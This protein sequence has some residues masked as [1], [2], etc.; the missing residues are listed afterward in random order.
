M[1]PDTVQR[2]STA[3]KLRQESD[4]AKAKELE[5]VPAAV[6]YALE[7]FK[8]YAKTGATHY[9]VQTF[10]D[11]YSPAVVRAAMET[12]KAEPHCFK[13][14]YTLYLGWKVSWGEDSNAG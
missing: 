14:E 11:A 4:F 10:G 7:R 1:N 12:L 5:K 9:W 2:V 13:V 8:A 3:Q 6:E